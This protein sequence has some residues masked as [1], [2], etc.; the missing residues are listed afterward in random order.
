[1]P[2]IEE[3]QRKMTEDISKI[4][5]MPFNVP[6]AVGNALIEGGQEIATGINPFEVTAKTIEKAIQIPQMA[7]PP[8]LKFPMF[9]GGQE[10]IGK[11]RE[12][13][14]AKSVMTTIY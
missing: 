8:E 2:G 13:S 9:V 11:K 10:R 3:F 1:M 5:A 12:A 14:Y 6:L 4:L 7:V